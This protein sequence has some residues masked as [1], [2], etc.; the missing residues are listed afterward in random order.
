MCT[1][2]DHYCTSFFFVVVVVFF[3]HVKLSRLVPTVKLLIFPIYGKIQIQLLQYPPTKFLFVIT[4]Y[5]MCAHYMV[6]VQS[7]FCLSLHHIKCVHT[8]WYWFSHKEPLSFTLHVGWS[9]ILI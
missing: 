1:H 4:S 6:L 8:T 2:I 9:E 5:Q 3:P 7:Y